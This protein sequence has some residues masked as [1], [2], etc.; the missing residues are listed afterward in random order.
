VLLLAALVASG[1]EASNQDVLEEVVVTATRIPT[2]LTSLPFAV[3]SVGEDQVQR[4][5]QQLGLDESLV[6][7]PGLFFQN[8][9]N[10]AQDLRIAIRGFG[11]R[12]NFGIRGIRIFA[13]DIPLT[14]PDG[15][16]SVDAID[17]GSVQQIDVIRGPFS[18]VYGSASG[19]VINIRTED[20]PE[21]PFLSARLNFGSYDYSQGQV[22]A[23]GQSG[24]L[25]WLAN[26]SATKL[27]GYRDHAEFKSRLFNSK[28]RYDFSEETRLTVVFNAVDSPRANDPGG[29][30]AR[31][32]AE[33]RRQA[34]PRNLLYNAGESLDQQSLGLAFRTQVRDGQELM[35]RNYYVHR[36][37]SNR[38]PFDVNSNGQ[39]GSVD[40]GRRFAGIGGNYGWTGTI[41]GRRNHL[42]LGLDHDAQRDHRK[43]YANN[44]G[45]LGEL[46]TNQDE[47]VTTTGLY[48][49]NV[50]DF[51]DAASLTLGGRWDNVDYE[52]SDRTGGGGSGSRDFNEFSPMAGINWAVREA[53]NLYGNISRSFDPP[54]TTELANP[55]GPTGFN[56]DLESQ[57]ATNYEIGVKGLLSGKLRYELAL[58]HIKVR[59]EIVPFEL[60]G[61]GQSFFQNAGRSSHDGLEAAITLDLA[62]GLAGTAT[63]TWSDF[64][65]DD[66][67]GIG[68]EV[69]DGNRIPGIPQHLFNLDLNWAHTS[70]FYAAW[71]FLYVGE[72]YA[73]NANTVET[74]DYLVSNLRSGFRWQKNQWVF[75]P[76]IGIS[77]LFDKEY[78][79]NV[80]LN[81]SFGRY[82]EPA[83]ERNFYAGF[84]LRYGF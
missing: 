60:E 83:P 62:E 55:D 47:D 15:Q 30:N 44:Q 14:L 39:G 74:D 54:A 2:E 21:S 11:A 24:K 17:L 59:D 79:A 77:N 41:A 42:V 45:T 27:D 80:R 69:Y 29:L 52:V 34:A 3:G 61:S 72:F 20:G 19:G 63:Y 32:V 9:Y 36:D 22:K 84:L 53:V 8:R 13:D 71:D 7:I 65:F 25:N 66:F 48:I 50:L 56:Q 73:D 51:A 82:Y 1:A 5:R 35:I 75:E 6:A 16:G 40:L 43:R 12:A 68:G 64:T 58:F 26:A 57:T 10:F 37:F 18:A 46:T 67:V 28:F 49:Q 81:A 23:G 33:D 78:M 76:F 38:L 31:E 70:G 4:A